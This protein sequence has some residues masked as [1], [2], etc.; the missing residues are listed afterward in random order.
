[1]KLEDIAGEICKAILPI[2][3]EVFFGNPASRVAICTLSSMNLL[4][5]IA[6]SELL[7][8]VVVAG[9]LL[10]ENK[11]I[12]AIISFV[13]KNPTLDTLILC[14]K[15]VSGHRAGHS[16]V[17]LYKYGVDENDRIINSTS[18]DPVLISTRSQIQKF[19]KQITLIDKIGETD[20]QEIRQLIRSL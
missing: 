10:S 5:E 15:E 11:G 14:G 16:L 8:E 2:H 17:S 4:K 1:M 7:S 20:L 19:Q 6:R 13:V 18:P 9:R 3:E 12:D